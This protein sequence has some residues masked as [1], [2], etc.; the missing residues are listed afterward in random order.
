MPFSERLPH[1]YRITSMSLG[2]QT[3]DMSSTNSSALR[4]RH[5][6]AGEQAYL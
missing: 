5:V 2:G 1:T 4:V 3:D 6:L